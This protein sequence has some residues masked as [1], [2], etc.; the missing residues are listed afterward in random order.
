MKKR[1]KTT[2]GNKSL[3]EIEDEEF[4]AKSI[5]DK[6]TYHGRRDNLVKYTN[7]RVKKRSFKHRE[8]QTGQ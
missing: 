5:E 6:A 2:Q 8:L 7:R 1:A 4:I 3:I